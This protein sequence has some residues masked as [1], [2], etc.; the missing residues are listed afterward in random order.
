MRHNSLLCE[1][2]NRYRVQSDNTG[3]LHVSLHEY[4]TVGNEAHDPISILNLI[5]QLEEKD[6]ALV[7]LFAQLLLT[8]VHDCKKLYVSNTILP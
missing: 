5:F 7:F 8:S 6:P 2:R 3:G 1:L 4:I